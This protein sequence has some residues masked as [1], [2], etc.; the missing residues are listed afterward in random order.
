MKLNKFREFF[1]S[2]LGVFGKKNQLYKSTEYKH[3]NYNGHNVKIISHDDI[4]GEVWIDGKLVGRDSEFSDDFEDIKTAVKEYIDEEF[5]K[6]VVQINEL[7]I[8]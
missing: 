4:E 6:N 5:G 8:D 1:K 7:T 3:F 2:E